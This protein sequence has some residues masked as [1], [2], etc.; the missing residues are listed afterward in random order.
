MSQE[1]LLTILATPQAEK[2]NGTTSALEIYHQ[3][4]QVEK[5]VLLD[6]RMSSEVL[7]AFTRIVHNLPNFD[8]SRNDE[9]EISEPIII[10]GVSMSL[11]LLIKTDPDKLDRCLTARLSFNLSDN[12]NPFSSPMIDKPM[13]ILDSGELCCREIRFNSKKSTTLVEGVSRSRSVE[14]TR[15]LP[16]QLFLLAHFLTRALIAK[17]K[18]SGK[19]LAIIEDAAV[20]Q[21]TRTSSGWSGR[22]ATEIGFKK[23][24]F[25]QLLL[26]SS[27]PCYTYQYQ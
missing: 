5:Q 26:R 7:I 16:T 14:I 18:F 11:S 17:S 2:S 19:I 9:F 13:G 21:K 6:P 24:R 20:D 23:S 15:G 27:H 12:D 25:H 4:K 10:N 1:E 8:F 3:L 22:R